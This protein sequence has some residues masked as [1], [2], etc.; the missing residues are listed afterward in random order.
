MCLIADTPFCP[1][2]S[3]THSSH[4]ILIGGSRHHFIEDFTTRDFD[5]IRLVSAVFPPAQDLIRTSL[6]P[7]AGFRN[8]QGGPAVGVGHQGMQTVFDQ[9]LESG[10]LSNQ[11]VQDSL[12]LAR[13]LHEGDTR[14]GKPAQD[15]LVDRLEDLVTVLFIRIAKLF[16]LVIL[17]HDKELEC[18]T[19]VIIPR[20]QVHPS[21]LENQEQ[22]PLFLPHAVRGLADPVVRE[23]V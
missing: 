10:G 5:A 2:L 14:V 4:F 17:S 6:L 21:C 23:I 3:L 9:E 1:H 19:T 15:L 16:P 22:T 20:G 18:G 13:L 7:L 11:N 12:V 8:V